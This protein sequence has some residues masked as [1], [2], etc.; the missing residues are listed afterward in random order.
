VALTAAAAAIAARS[1]AAEQA[2]PGEPTSTRSAPATLKQVAPETPAET[3]A[4]E[5]AREK[6]KIRVR[7]PNYYGR[8]VDSEQREKIYAIQR[9]YAPKIE[10]LEAQLAALEAERDERVEGVLTAEQ[11]A[12]VKELR[13]EAK[14]KRA[15]ARAAKAAA[16]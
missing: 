7:L 5:A 3:P 2:S 14:A 13:A 6:K 8:V 10:A 16:E 9:E 11:L 15:R 4:P 1:L 12:K